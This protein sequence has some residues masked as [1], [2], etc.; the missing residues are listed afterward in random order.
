M[1]NC[2]KVQNLISCYIDRELP[3]TDMLT[4]QR[5]LDVCPECRREYQSLLMVKQ[6]LSEMPIAPPSDSLEQRLVGEVF[7]SAAPASMWFLPI[8]RQLVR[9]LALAAALGAITLGVWYFG[10]QARSPVER[11][12]ATTAG[13]ANEVDH[14]TIDAYLS[15][16]LHLQKQPYIPAEIPLH[17]YDNRASLVSVRYYR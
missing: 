16:K 10:V 9:P 4:V 12:F 2:A 6:L 17:P 13:T 8:P 7:R 11:D 1:M 15:G 14:A 5:H 3:G